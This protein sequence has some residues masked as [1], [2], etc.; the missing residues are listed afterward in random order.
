MT[1]NSRMQIAV[2]IVVFSA[3]YALLIAKDPGIASAISSGYVAIVLTAILI[4][5]VRKKP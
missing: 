3:L 4:S 1:S 5:N 2:L